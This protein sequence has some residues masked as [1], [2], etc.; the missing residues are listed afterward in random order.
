MVLAPV[1]MLGFD[2]AA[3]K[4]RLSLAPAQ[5]LSVG[6]PAPTPTVFSKA[7]TDTVARARLHQA[8]FRKEILAAYQDRCC[9][10]EL[11][12][13]PLLDAAHIL[14]DRL[15]DGVPTVRNGL[16][17]CPTHHRAYDKDILL[18]TE[19]YRV[20]VRDGRLD[21]VGDDAT[22]ACCSTSMGGRS[23]CRRT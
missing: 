1:A 23:G 21:H 16:A 3:R 12:E 13:R 5:E 22:P 14:P 15:P 6:V 17:M 2:D 11:R 7:Y 8:H 20:E 18:V 10:C 4:V 19:R 9:I